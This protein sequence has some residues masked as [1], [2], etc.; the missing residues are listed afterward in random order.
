MMQGVSG[1]ASKV[2]CN[3]PLLLRFWNRAFYKLPNDEESP[4]LGNLDGGPPDDEGH[5]SRTLERLNTFIDISTNSFV[6][7]LSWIYWLGTHAFNAAGHMGA[8]L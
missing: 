1:F 3:T 4:A 2:H 6:T 8:L 7:F 5:D